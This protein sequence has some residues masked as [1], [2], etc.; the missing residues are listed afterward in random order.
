VFARQLVCFYFMC[1]ITTT[2][3]CFCYGNA[4]EP[5]LI[6]ITL[7]SFVTSGEICFS[8]VVTVVFFHSSFLVDS[9]LQ[10]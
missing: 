5:Q 4:G 8:F 3:I 9:L 10:F 1:L 2:Y 6:R 7:F